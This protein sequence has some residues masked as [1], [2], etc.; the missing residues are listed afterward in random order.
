M[1]RTSSD[2]VNTPS[3]W[4]NAIL[5]HL[6][7]S[8]PVCRHAAQYMRENDI[9]IGFG[10]Q[11]TGARWTL[12]GNIDMNPEWFP[13]RM[14]TNPTDAIMLGLIVH[15][16]KH[17]EQGTALALSVQGELGGWQAQ[18]KAHIELGS[19]IEEDEH[20]KAINTLDE[21]TSKKLRQARREMLRKEGFGYLIWLLPLRANLLTHVVAKFYSI[22]RERISEKKKR[23]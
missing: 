7:K 3:T 16:A 6:E 10:K 5:E 1:N 13:A 9:E 23:A 4:R 20:W 17:L 21:R 22:S 14:E 8:G 11:K 2:A 12:E 19:P 18:Y 15:E